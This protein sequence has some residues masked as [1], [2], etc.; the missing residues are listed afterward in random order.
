MVRAFTYIF[1]DKDWV[2]KIAIL[3]ILSLAAVLL[4]V[5]FIGLIAVAI[6]LG[7]MLET[8]ANV[9]NRLGAPLPVWD[10]Y[11]EKLTSGFNILVAAFV[12][13]LP[14]LLL[15]GCAFWMVN[16]TGNG[17]LAG[18]LAVGVVCCL[19]PLLLI[20]NLL[21]WPMLAVGTI[22]YM[23]TGQG[24]ALF[25]FGPILSTMQDHGNA[26][27]QW[28]FYTVLANVIFAALGI[29]PCLGW[30]LILALSVPVHA[31]LLGQY[32][33]AIRTKGKPAPQKAKHH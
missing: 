3:V 21:V 20:Y 29:I 30:V 26:T 7:Y 10:N 6:L 19:V 16:G 25:Q 1:D 13:N 11:P 27:L 5:L 12:Y 24:N 28:I 2:S 32:A 31:H 17:L 15:G 8:A 14:T 23:D 33:L 9:R 18:G 22:R 4:S